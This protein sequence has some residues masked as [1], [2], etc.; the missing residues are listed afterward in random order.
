MLSLDSLFPTYTESAFLS[1]D[2]SS[3]NMELT[4][5]SVYLQCVEG[6]LVHSE[7]SKMLPK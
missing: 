5:L 4:Y 2:V 1:Y 3:E 7:Y 6:H